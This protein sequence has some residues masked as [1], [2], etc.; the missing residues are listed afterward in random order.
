MLKDEIFHWNNNVSI[1]GWIKS[2]LKYDHMVQN[3][4]MY[5][6]TVAIPQISGIE[7]ILPVCLSKKLASQGICKNMFVSIKASLYL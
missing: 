6:C 4:E 3:T 5:S 2:D 7:D 1:K